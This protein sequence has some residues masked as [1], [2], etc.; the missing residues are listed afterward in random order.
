MS[1]AVKSFFRLFTSTLILHFFSHPPSLYIV[2]A[3]SSFPSG[4]RPVRPRWLGWG[5]S[6]GPLFIPAA[7][8]DPTVNYKLHRAHPHHDRRTPIVLAAV[9]WSATARDVFRC[10]GGPGSCTAIQLNGHE[11]CGIATTGP[12]HL[13]ADLDYV[14][15]T[16]SGP[17]GADQCARRVCGCRPGVRPR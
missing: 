1:S 4:L 5:S 7:R 6:G 16:V 14:Q 12:N 10:G 13:R 9:S 15:L 8:V 11:D 17:K 3:L 2:A